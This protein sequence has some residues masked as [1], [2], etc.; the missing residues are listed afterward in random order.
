MCWGIQL[1]AEQSPAALIATASTARPNGVHDREIRAEPFHMHL[2]PASQV[3]CNISM[4]LTEMMVKLCYTSKVQSRNQRVNGI[5]KNCICVCVRVCVWQMYVHLY[6]WRKGASPACLNVGQ[7]TCVNR[8][9]SS[10]CFFVTTYAQVH[11]EML[12][13]AIKG[14]MGSGG[15]K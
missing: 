6:Y 3:S 2:S 11:R 13:T 4:G 8:M 12:F 1:T 15:V 5:F 9:S 10:V 14:S 7:N